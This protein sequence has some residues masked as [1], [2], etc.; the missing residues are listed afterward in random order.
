MRVAYFDC[1]SGAAGD[2]IVGA[3]LDA[4]ADFAALRSQLSRLPVS[5]Y[6]LTA[7]RVKK[8]GL[9]ATKFDVKI[10]D[11]SH[12]HRHL[13][14]IV[15]IIESADLSDR[16][17]EQSLRIFHRLAE[18]E[19][20]VHGC[21]IE[22]VHFHEVGA[23]DAIVDIVGACVCFDLLG[24]DRVIS[25]PVATGNGTVICEHGELPVPAPA[26]AHLLRGVPV[27]PC[28]EMGELLTPT[29]AAILTTLADSFGAVPAMRIEQI[30]VGAGTRDGARRPNVV[31]ALIGESGAPAERDE[32]VLLETNLD[33]ATGETI[34]HTL[35]RLFAGGALDAYCV[36]IQMKKGRPGVILTVLAAPAD[37][38]RLEAM[39]F[40]ETGTFGVRRRPAARAT[41][42]RTHE[43]VDTQYGAIRVKVG[44]RAGRH[45]IASPEFEDCRRAATDHGV[46]LREVMAETM[47]RWNAGRAG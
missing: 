40:E 17:R 12:P 24:I 15:K 16:V 5:G 1:F 30:G 34:G 21:A 4:G 43:T 33:D 2:M 10:A 25:S 35:D 8:Q 38:D 46:P 18:A 39:I 19:A 41:L 31:R 36:P 23:V 20:A 11:G 6:E 26:T 13:K 9:A 27:A 29:G 45:V 42:S 32:I 14:D 44:A 28:E 47:R 7:E 22:K 37:A 3:L